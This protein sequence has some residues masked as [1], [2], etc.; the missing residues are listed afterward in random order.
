MCL[1]NKL[2]IA[3]KHRTSDASYADLN[4]AGMHRSICI[5]TEAFYGALVVS[6]VAAVVLT[7]YGLSLN[8]DFVGV[9]REPVSV[10]RDH[11]VPLF[12]PRIHTLQSQT[13][14]ATIAGGRLPDNLGNGIDTRNTFESK[15]IAF[16]AVRSARETLSLCYRPLVRCTN[17]TYIFIY[18]YLFTCIYYFYL[19]LKLYICMC[20]EVHWPFQIYTDRVL[21][22]YILYY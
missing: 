2:P 20:N 10:M 19:I 8:R 11:P 1:R 15:N 17:W 22:Q 18:I 13:H 21:Y 14:V 7:P 12:L 3:E 16:T 4:Y 6:R 9:F 5:K